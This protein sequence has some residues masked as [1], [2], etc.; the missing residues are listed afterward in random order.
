M[1]TRTNHF[2]IGL[3]VLAALVLLL[4]GLL[5]FGAR[6]Y[7]E[8]RTTFETC[9]PGDAEGLSVGS[10]VK[11][12]GVPIGQVT[13]I[14]FTW[15]VYPKSSKNYVVVQF[16]IR[17]AIAAGRDG[18]P[19]QGTRTE[20]DRGLRALVKGQGITGTSIISLEYMDP[21]QHPPPEIDFTPAHHYI[22]SAPSQFS[23][24]LASFEKTLR[25]LEKLQFDEIS[26]GLSE[27]LRSADRL[28]DNVGRVDFAAFSTNVNSLVLEFKQTSLKM[29]AV[30]DEVRD[31]VKGMG[32]ESVG[33]NADKLLVELRATNVRLQ[34]SV[35]RFDATALNESVEQI[36][37][38]AGKLNYVL[39]ELKRYPS[40]FLFGQPP[41][42]ARS[43]SPP[44]R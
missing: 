1:S 40:G 41:P 25:N 18:D 39:D 37:E 17:N 2:K 5:A 42:A 21:S 44:V 12:R 43:V 10:P 16:Q 9:V 34:D 28:A 32:L 35:A 8:G 29:Q 19:R 26:K 13:R 27:T 33:Q 3:F 15:N 11:L 6:S 14:D 30:L 22:P 23:Q 24:I 38:A 20:V 4:A 31:V 7:F 36:R